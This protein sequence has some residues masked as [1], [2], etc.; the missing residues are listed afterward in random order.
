MLLTD[1]HPN[2]RQV[3]IVTGKH[4]ETDSTGGLSQDT[5]PATMLCVGGGYIGLELGTFYS[6][7]GSKVTVVEARSYRDW[8]TS[9]QSRY[10]P[11]SQSR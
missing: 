2:Q 8:E 3:C 5:V 6:K 11:V 1:A 9:S 7:V 4:W 10:G